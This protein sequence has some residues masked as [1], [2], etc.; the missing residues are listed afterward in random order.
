MNTLFTFL[1]NVKEL[2]V[3]WI[4]FAAFGLLY[5]YLSIP[6]F[7]TVLSQDIPINLIC[8][9]NWLE[10]YHCVRKEDLLFAHRYN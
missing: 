2:A 7:D 1:D 5:L 3:V 9:E 6:N 10:V 4:A 8:E